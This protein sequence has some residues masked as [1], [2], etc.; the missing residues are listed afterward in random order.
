MLL[1]DTTHSP[2]AKLRPVPLDAVTFTDSFWVPR[3]QS[4]RKVTLPMQL[5]Q[6]EQTGR[7]DN[8][9]RAAGWIEGPR[10]GFVYD[11]S[12]VYKWLEAVAWTYSSGGE[13]INDLD[14]IISAILAAQQPDGYLNTAFMFDKVGQRWTNLRD[15][16]ELYCAGH[17]IQAAVAHYR[18]TADRRLLT[19]ACKLAGL[20]C[21]TFG[22]ESTGRQPGVPGHQEIEIALIEL[23]RVTG[24]TRYLDQSIYFLDA[25]GRGLIGGGSYHQDHTPYRDLTGHT[26]HA[27]RALYMN[28]AA[29]D[30][31]LETGDPTLLQTLIRLWEHTTSRQM[32]VTGGLGARHS[33]ESFGDDYELPNHRAYAETCAAIASMMW[34]YRMLL[35]TGNAQYADLLEHTLYNAVLPGISLEGEHYFYVNLLANEGAHRRQPWFACACCPPNLARLLAS[36]SGYF[37]SLSDDNALWIHLYADGVVRVT[38]PDGTRLAL[39][40]RTSYPWKGDIK[41]TVRGAGTFA[42]NL[43]VP[44]WCPDPALTLNGQPLDDPANPGAYH[45]IHRSWR[46]GDAIALHLPM[47]VRFLE[48][49]PSI[50]ENTGKVAIQRGPILYC[51]ESADNPF[52]LDDVYLDLTGPPSTQ[53]QSDLLNDI[54]ALRVLADHRPPSRP[55]K[56]HLY[57]PVELP[58]Q[59]IPVH[60]PSSPGQ[61]LTAIPYFAWANRSPG[62]MRIWLKKAV[63]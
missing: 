57:R 51:L 40:V 30:I 4:L 17:F 50:S 44:G 37:Y 18:T 53:Y 42:I 25:R 23:Y 60:L 41:L 15:W 63:C 1:V 43:R 47:P 11:D 26:G 9:R 28:V 3:L 7:L 39:E 20:I 35:L 22:P 14:S 13:C 59:M 2:Y 58:P 19:A 52:N 29:A 33:G 38:L 32:Y 49:H 61:S 56:D 21:G 12:D 16:H 8:F 34:N 46:D 55:W 31:C 5:A 10:R 24:E 27:V 45:A 6:I 48:S 36:I 62:Q 54:V